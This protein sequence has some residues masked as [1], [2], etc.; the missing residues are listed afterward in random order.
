MNNKHSI[1][2]KDL[3]KKYLNHDDIE[4]IR[5]E[6]A[7]SA[8]MPDLIVQAPNKTIYMEIKHHHDYLSKTQQTWWRR[9]LQLNQKCFIMMYVW[10]ENK[11][12]YG[13]YLPKNPHKRSWGD[14]LWSSSVSTNKLRNILFDE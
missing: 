8:G 12:S 13:L 11:F 3:K 9:A 6:N 5:V 4:V 2:I 7:F 10:Q 1:V 14:C